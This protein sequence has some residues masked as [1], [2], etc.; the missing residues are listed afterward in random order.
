MTELIRAT[1][2]D[3]LAR[4]CYL[5]Q[6]LIAPAF[7]GID[8]GLAEKLAI[9]AATNTVAVAPDDA[10]AA[11]VEADEFAAAVRA[12]RG[13]GEAAEA[14]LPARKRSVTVGDVVETLHHIA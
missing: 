8:L 3:E 4:V 11:G 2:V 7:A 1:P 5:C 12:R 14:L 10:T 13:L 9:R 6:G